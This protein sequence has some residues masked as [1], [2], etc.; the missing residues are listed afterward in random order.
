MA[1]CVLEPL[2]LQHKAVPLGAETVR[3]WVY[4]FFPPP[5]LAEQG[6]EERHV[7]PKLV[8]F[9]VSVLAVVTNKVETPTCLTASLQDPPVYANTNSTTTDIIHNHSNVYTTNN[10][11]NDDI[12]MILQPS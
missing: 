8:P 1:P 7:T 5:H 2:F 3:C 9:R 10:N 4:L 12:L 11:H 6:G